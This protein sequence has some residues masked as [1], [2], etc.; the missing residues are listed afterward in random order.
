MTR[1]WW[2]PPPEPHPEPDAPHPK[3]S[4]CPADRD[5]CAGGRAPRCRHL[6][7]LRCNCC[8]EGDHEA[9]ES[10]DVHLPAPQPLALSYER[11]Q[12]Q[13]LRHRTGGQPH[14]A[15]RRRA[16][17]RAPGRQPAPRRHPLHHRPGHP[18]R[19]PGHQNRLR[20]GLRTQGSSGHRLLPGLDQCLHRQP[21]AGRAARQAYP[22]RCLRA[23]LPASSR[24]HHPGHSQGR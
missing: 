22:G 1:I 18:Q 16:V 7:G 15:L 20:S 9:L 12:L 4:H 17:G 14:P 19:R 21:H 6:A 24:R 5:R 8:L 13:R 10:I 3:R 23:R 11:G 2:G